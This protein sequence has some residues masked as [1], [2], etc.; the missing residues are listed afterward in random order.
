MATRGQLPHFSSC[1]I[2]VRAQPELSAVFL[3]EGD[4][5]CCRCRCRW[6]I[7]VCKTAC[8][9]SYLRL[10]VAA[11]AV[12]SRLAPALSLKGSVPPACDPPRT[13]GTLAVLPSPRVLTAVAAELAGLPG[14]SPQTLRQAPAALW[15]R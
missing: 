2:L 7:K 9:E 5:G 6:H 8:V 14:V 3:E 13:P 1:W 11:W 15:A 4:V 10:R 12:C